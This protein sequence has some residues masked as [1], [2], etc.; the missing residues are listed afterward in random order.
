[1]TSLQT[2]DYGLSYLAQTNS[3]SKS[4]DHVAQTAIEYDRMAGHWPLLHDLMA[5]TYAMRM[6]AEQW[7]PKEP[8]ETRGAYV[9]RLNRSFLYNAYSDTVEK[10][11]SKPFSR[12]VSVQGEV[13]PPLDLI[14]EDVDMSGRDLTQLGRDVFRSLVV[15]GVAHV[16]VDFPKTEGVE[17]L[18]DERARQIRPTFIHVSPTNLIGWRTEKQAN[19]RERLTQ[20]RIMEKRIE[21]KGEFTEEEI[22]YVR[23]ITPDTFEVWRQSEDEEDKFTKV[24]EGTHSFGDVPLVS[25][26]AQRTGFLTGH[27]PLLDLA[28]LNLAHWQSLSDQ[29]NCLRFARVGLLFA[30]GF[31]DE[32][33]ENGISI[34][35][36]QLIAATNPDSKLTYVEH[37]GSAIKAGQDDLDALERR[38]ETLGLQPLVQRTGS[39][40]ATGKAIDESRVHTAIQAWIRSVENCLREAY[41]LAGSWMRLDLPEDFSIDITNDFGVSLRAT[42]DIRALLDLRKTGDISRETFLRELKRRGLLSEGLDI[43]DEIEAAEMESL[44]AQQ[45]TLMS[46]I[47]EEDDDDD[48]GDPTE[49][50]FENEDEA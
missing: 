39:Q 8:R 15:Y 40:T 23:V 29:R 5:G 41:M 13:S 12:P 28:Q 3:G 11:V 27:P 43:E 44:F 21:A 1:M 22:S 6:A 46:A 50:R 24:E 42:D 47:E 34:G 9:N 2:R 35:P 19:G 16:L 37:K 17:T 33:L 45:Q 32:E 26:Y 14:Q 10:L 7:L 30:S 4:E 36:N 38:M 25:C 48:E 18:A 20:I 31:S 49:E